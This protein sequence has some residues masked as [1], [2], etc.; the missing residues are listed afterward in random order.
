MEGDVINVGQQKQ[1][2]DSYIERGVIVGF[3]GKTLI[4]P[5]PMA[6]V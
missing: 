2:I 4:T 5:K 6:S 3:H 1:F